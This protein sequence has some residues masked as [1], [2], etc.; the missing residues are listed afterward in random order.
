M[1]DSNAN[2]ATSQSLIGNRPSPTGR[3]SGGPRTAEGKRRSCQNAR[4]HGLYTDERFLE[5]AA[6]ELGDDPRQLQRLLNGLIEARRPVGALEM[7]LVEGIALL[8]CRQ[9]RLDRAELAVQVSNLH[10]HDLERDKLSIKVGHLNSDAVESEVREH[11]LRRS[12]DTPGKFE[13]V[14]GFL[15]S[16]V[17]MID[18]NEFGYGM[19]EALIALCGSDFTLWGVKLD[20]YRYGL[21]KMPPGEAREKAKNGMA[22]WV[23]EEIADVGREYE[24]FLHEHVENT[25]SARMA[26]TAPSQAQW[27]VIIRQQNSLDRQLERKIR[28]LME[29]QQERKSEARE[30]LEASSPPDPG[31]PAA[32]HPSTT[33][34]AQ[35]SSCEVC[36]ADPNTGGPR[37]L[38]RRGP[39]RLQKD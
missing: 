36:A 1:E 37:Y 22:R 38:A 7:A 6:L 28:S 24:L 35:T 18:K 33:G 17:A 15:T 12:L 11:G 27:A 13:Q 10:Q 8:L 26:A 39:R 31:A 23:A 16:L 25:R 3:R 14:L 2:Q 9:A 29:L 4:R 19:R 34:M 20:E 5:G 30:S 21:A 32:V